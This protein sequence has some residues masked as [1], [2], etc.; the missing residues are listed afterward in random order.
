MKWTSQFERLPRKRGRRQSEAPGVLVLLLVAVFLAPT[1]AFGATA[2]VVDTF[3]AP[4]TSVIPGSV[5]PLTLAAHDPDCLSAPCTSGC[6]MAINPAFLS[7]T[8]DTGRGAAAFQALVADA[9]ESPFSASVHWIAPATE[10]TVVVTASVSDNGSMLC[11]GRKTTITTLTFT[12][13]TV[14]NHSPVIS[15]LTA[16]A[17]VLFPGQS[18]IVNAV[19]LDPDV[20]PITFAWS[21]TAGT[22]APAAAGAATLLAPSSPASVTVTCTVTDS[23]GAQ[24]SKTLPISVTSA[25]PERSIHAGLKAP[26]RVAINSAGELFVV[27]PS[28]GGIAVIGLFTGQ[29]NC[30]WPLQLARSVAVDWA[31]GIVIGGAPGAAVYDRALTLVRTFDPGSP[32][33]G[34]TDVAV[35]RTGHRYGLLYGDAGRIAIFGASGGP[36]LSFGANGS[37]PGELKGAASIAFT[38]L[39]DVL[40]GDRGHGVV[41]LYSGVSGAFVSSYGAPG[42]GPGGF[43]QVD[44]VASDAAGKLLA[45]DTFFSLVHEF[46]PGG[47]FQE[48]LGGWGTGVGQLKTPAGLL[49]SDTFQRVIVTSANSSRLEIFRLPG[50]GVSTPL[51]ALSTT[52]LQFGPQRVGLSSPAQTVTLTSAGNAPVSISNTFPTGDFS[53]VGNT[54]G[55]SL[56]PGQSCGIQVV[57]HPMAPGTLAGALTVASN[58]P[59]GTSSAMLTGQGTAAAVVTLVLSPLALHFGTIDTGQISANQTLTVTASGGSV[60]IGSVTLA[61]VLPTTATGKAEEGTLAAS[62]FSIVASTCNGATVDNVNGCTVDIVFHP[63]SSGARTAYALV[64][65]QN[66]TSLLGNASLDGAG[67]DVNAVSIPTLGESGLALFA[68][69]LAAAGA[70]FLGR[71]VS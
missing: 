7:F 39:G 64:W 62:D 27:D 69:A 46:A 70:G 28:L 63:S 20:D 26:Q 61:S 66:G 47:A 44:G 1:P 23:K 71:R 65:A 2:P 41:Q 17:A 53:I 12:V 3:S 6:G 30:F 29:M 54:C 43:S 50:P 14:L 40:V 21:T 57:F 11:G 4:S 13:S 8:D 33:G 31:D 67:A 48:S 24:T 55:A 35:D 59:S 25:M 38:P 45:A 52:L 37:N 15:S 16:G 51:L 36:T 22:I 32:L 19:A 34:V 9:Q 49:V 58:V 5:T 68:L 18:T 42:S 10:G 60:T 56:A